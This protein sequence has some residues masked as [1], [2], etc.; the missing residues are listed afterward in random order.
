[1]KTKQGNDVTYRIGAVSLKTK[2]GYLHWLDRLSSM[3]KTRY[4]NDYYPK[5]AILRLQFNIF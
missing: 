4:D 5:S 3:M 2:L 1:M